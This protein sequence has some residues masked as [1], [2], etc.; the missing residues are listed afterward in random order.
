MT[1]TPASGTYAMVD[2]AHVAEVG[3]AAAILFARIL[4]RS[5]REG[6]WRATRSQ[7]SQE[8]GLSAAM[9]RTAVEVLRTREWVTTARTSAEDATLVWTPICAGQPDMVDSTPPPAESAPPPLR[10][11]PHPP[12]ESAI[13]SLETDR[14]L[15]TP[16]NTP[17]EPDLFTGP[18]APAPPALSVVPDLD[19]EFVRF[20]VLYPRKVAKPVALKSYKRARLDTP[21]E[22]IAHGLRAQ[23]PELLARERAHVPH[24]STWLNQRRWE[25]A[26]EDASTSSAPRHTGRRN[27]F[28]DPAMGGPTA[29]VMAAFN[30]HLTA[31][32]RPELETRR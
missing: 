29:D 10:D 13:S 6:S 22:D 19:A 3:P 5:Q 7:L 14:D 11:S 23:L 27:V 4:W 12:A 32:T 25:D 1:A 31:P 9:L 15:T 20:W 24:P 30:A 18:T 28:A 2:P 8:T 16:P 21:V 26:P 17:H